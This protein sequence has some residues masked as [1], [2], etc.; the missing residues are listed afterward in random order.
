MDELDEVLSEAT[1]AVTGPYFQLPIA[2]Q[3]DLIYRER[4]YCY[5]LYHQM[6]VRWPKRC[7]YSLGGEVDKSG[8]PLMRGNGLDNLKPDFL[9]HRP[10]DMKSNYAVIE[11]KPANASVAGLRKDLETLSI[12]QQYAGYQ[13]SLLLIYGTISDTLKNN[14]ETQI[15][16][17]DTRI[18]FWIHSIVGKRAENTIS[19]QG[20]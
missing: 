15:D 13:R 14:L 6:R 17:H 5:E 12:F 20:D 1:A 3:V 7:R 10:R 19:T 16:G 9:I 8:H 2:G 11:V 18:E 4:V